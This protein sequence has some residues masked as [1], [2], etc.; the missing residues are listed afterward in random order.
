MLRVD[1]C[2]VESGG[3]EQPRNL[4]GTELPEVEAELDSTRFQG[5]SYFINDHV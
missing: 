4:G 1:E 3:R 5:A 2:P